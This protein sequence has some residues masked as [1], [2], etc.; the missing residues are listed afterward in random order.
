MLCWLVQHSCPARETHPAARCSAGGPTRPAAPSHARRLQTFYVSPEYRLAFIRLSA[1]VGGNVAEQPYID[2][3]P[4]EFVSCSFQ[5]SHTAMLADP[6]CMCHPE[7]CYLPGFIC[8]ALGLAHKAEGLQE[9]SIAPL[10]H[11]CHC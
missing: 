8:M 10:L 1:P 3:F 6:P 9:C 4:A 7:C 5:H 2:I 11:C